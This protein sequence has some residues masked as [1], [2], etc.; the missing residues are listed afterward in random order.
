MTS[1]LS[2]SFSLCTNFNGVQLPTVSIAFVYLFVDSGFGIIKLSMTLCRQYLRLTC[3]Q[4]DHGYFLCAYLI[5]IASE[6]KRNVH[7]TEFWSIRCIKNH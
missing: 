5:A 4:V 6:M 2:A 1:N 3:Y 7:S